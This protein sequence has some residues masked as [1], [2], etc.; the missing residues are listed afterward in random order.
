MTTNQIVDK[1]NKEL[2]Q[3]LIPD[4]NLEIYCY[5]S[6]NPEIFNQPINQLTDEK[7]S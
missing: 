6:E 3:N 2:K 1:F 5:S 7:D 4:Y